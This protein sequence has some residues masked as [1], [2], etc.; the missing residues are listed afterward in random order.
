[1]IISLIAAMAENRVIGR[2]GGLPWRL[3]RDVQHFKRVTTGH[4]VI[5]G[6]RTYDSVGAPL[7]NRRNMVVTRNP[8]Y[9][10]PG[11]RAFPSLDGALLAADDDEVFVVGGAEIYRLAFRRAARLYL[12][13][14]HAAVDG[15]TFFPAFAM[16]DWRLDEDLRYPSDERHAY[17]C[18]FRL[19]T[20]R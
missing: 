5:M 2:G 12:T 14:V 9:R 3:P 13:V 19:Y 4:T 8:D 7:P 15:D 17:S 16:D 18:S 10:P 1:M 20:R 6:R 11:I